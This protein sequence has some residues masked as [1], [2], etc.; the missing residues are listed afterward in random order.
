MV[1]DKWLAVFATSKIIDAET[2]Y[3]DYSV[4]YDVKGVIKYRW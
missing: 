1:L 2:N 4:W 3:M